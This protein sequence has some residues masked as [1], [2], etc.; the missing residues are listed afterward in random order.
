MIYAIVAKPDVA[1]KIGRSNQPF[2]RLDA[3]RTGSP[4]PLDLVVCGYGGEFEEVM[5]HAALAEYR[6]HGEWFESEYGGF[7]RLVTV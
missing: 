3:L 6:L 7:P 5:I 2:A 4:H 1:I